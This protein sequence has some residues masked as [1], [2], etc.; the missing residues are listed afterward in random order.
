MD[1]QIALIEA[2]LLLPGGEPK[3]EDLVVARM[4]AI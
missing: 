1:S 2:G 4:C 3:L